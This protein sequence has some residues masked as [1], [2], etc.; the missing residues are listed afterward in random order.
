VGLP[1]AIVSGGVAC[2]LGAAAFAARMPSF[3]RYTRPKRSH[4]SDDA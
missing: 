4:M 2:I 1:F 3:A